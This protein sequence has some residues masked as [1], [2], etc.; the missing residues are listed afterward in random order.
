M[1]RAEFCSKNRPLLFPQTF[2]H[3][4]MNTNFLR[5]EIFT[6]LFTVVNSKW[7]FPDFFFSIQRMIACSSQYIELCPLW[8]KFLNYVDKRGWWVGSSLRCQRYT[9]SLF[10]KNVNRRWVS[11]RIKKNNGQHSLRMS[12]FGTTIKCNLHIALYYY[13]FSFL[14]GLIS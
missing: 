9:M 11:I 4:K 5:T 7:F 1:V 13:T 12:P 6:Y 2:M 10:S 14:P 8:G 3:E